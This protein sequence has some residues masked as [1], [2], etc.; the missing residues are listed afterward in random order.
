MITEHLITR[1]DQQASQRMAE[2]VRE[3]LRRAR[4]SISRCTVVVTDDGRETRELIFDKPQTVGQLAERA[5][6]DI[7]VV[8]VAMRRVPRRERLALILAVE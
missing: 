6:P 5:G 2:K 8:S 4:P 3:G 1:L 7:W